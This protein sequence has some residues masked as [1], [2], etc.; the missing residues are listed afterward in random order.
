VT[1]TLIAKAI[2]GYSIS[3]MKQYFEIFSNLLSQEMKLKYRRT[4]FG[5]LWSLIN[6][7]L[8]LIVISFVF[9]H[10]VKWPLKNYTQYLFSGIFVCTFFQGAVFQSATSLIE[11]E[12][13]IKKIYLPKF[14]FP[15]T[16]TTFN[17][18]HFL[19]SLVVLMAVGFLMGFEVHWTVF[20][21]PLAFIP[22]FIFTLGI[23]T[24]L[25]VLTVYFRDLQQ[26]L[27]VFLQLLFYATPIMYPATAL[28]ENYQGLLQFNPFYS[29][30]VLFQKLIYFDTIPTSLEWSVASVTAIAFLLLG[31]F[32]L[33]ITEDQLVFEL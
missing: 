6:P 28:P 19:F 13:F 24:L 30:V 17:F 8:H 14:L 21:L 33:Q 22:L 29:Q 31:L 11:N 7:L 16:K 5:Y 23:S 25:S 12:A 18:I 26:M 27:G 32:S 15:F 3:V 2:Q 20:L 10:I 4:Y 9:S 1:Y